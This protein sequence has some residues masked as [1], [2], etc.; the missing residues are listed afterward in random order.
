MKFLK[1]Y[2]VFIFAFLF[3]SQISFAYYLYG[4][5]P[6]CTWR[7]VSDSGS[8]F[9]KPPYSVG[10]GTLLN[11]TRDFTQ[12]TGVPPQL[13]N[14]DIIRDYPFPDEYVTVRLAALT[15]GAAN[16]YLES[17]PQKL[18][19]GEI[20]Y[21]LDS[22]NTWN[23]NFTYIKGYSSYPGI[24]MDYFTSERLKVKNSGSIINRIYE[25]TLRPWGVSHLS[26]AWIS[27]EPAPERAWSA[28]VPAW[29][30][31]FPSPY[32]GYVSGTCPGGIIYNGNCCPWGLGCPVYDTYPENNGPG[33]WAGP[34]CSKGGT[35]C[36]VP[37]YPE[38][39]GDIL[40]N[41]PAI[42]PIPGTDYP[43]VP[44][45]P[46]VRVNGVPGISCDIYNGANVNA[47]GAPA[48]P[49]C[50]TTTDPEDAIYESYGI[51]GYQ[52]N[53]AQ[54]SAK[55]KKAL[56]N[57]DVVDAIYYHG[58]RE[59][60]TTKLDLTTAP[61]TAVNSVG[62]NFIL[63]PRVYDTC[64][65][66]AS[67]AQVTNTIQPVWPPNAGNEQLTYLMGGNDSDWDMV[68][69]DLDPTISM[70]DDYL[71]TQCSATD[72][73]CPFP[74]PEGWIPV[75]CPGDPGCE[76]CYNECAPTVCNYNAGYNSC[77]C[78]GDCGNPPGCGAGDENAATS[79]DNGLAEIQEFK[80]SHSVSNLYLKVQTQ[81]DITFG[82]YGS[83]YPIVGCDEWNFG[84]NE[85]HKFNGYTFS[86]V[87]NRTIAAY[88]LIIVP[89]I[90][91]YG[92]FMI[93]LDIELLKSGGLSGDVAIEDL[94]CNSCQLYPDSA[95]AMG[96]ELYVELGREGTVG[97]PGSDPFTSY[98]LTLGL[99][100]LDFDDLLDKIQM[101]NFSLGALA[102]DISPAINYYIG[103]PISRSTVEVRNDTT[104][105]KVPT[106][107]ACLGSCD[108]YD[109][110]ARK[111]EVR[112]DEVLFNNDAINSDLTDLGGY[113]LYMSRGPQT[114][115]SHYYTFCGQVGE[116]S[117]SPA[118]TANCNAQTPYSLDRN[119]PASDEP[120]LP[121]GT[122][123]PLPFDAEASE[124]GFGFPG[125]PVSCFIDT[126]CD[127]VGDNRD[128]DT[129]GDV[130]EGCFSGA[131]TTLP[132][133]LHNC[134]DD[135][136]SDGEMLKEDG[137]EYWFKAVAY[138]RPNGNSS[139]WSNIAKVKILRNTTP[140]SVT[141]LQ[142]IYAMRQ[143]RSIKVVWETNKESDM[144][145]YAVYRCPASPIAAVRLTEQGGLAL[146]NYCAND[147]N[148]RRVNQT[149]LSSPSNYFIDYGT[150]YYEGSCPGC[151][152][153]EDGDA[154][155]YEWFDCT[156]T[157]PSNEDLM[158]C[159]NIAT[160][161]WT[162]GNPLTLYPASDTFRPVQ[163]YNGLVDGYVYYYKMRAVDRP[164]AG[165]GTN[166]PG[167][168]DAG[169][170]PYDPITKQGCVNPISDRTC[171]DDTV[172]NDWS[173]GGNCSDMS[174]AVNDNPRTTPDPETPS[175]TQP[176]NKPTGISSSLNTDGTSVT[177][178]W[179]SYTDLSSS[180]YDITFDHSNVYRSAVENG[181]FA[182]VRGTC[183]NTPMADGC[184]CAADGDCDTGRVCDFGVKICTDP[185][186]YTITPQTSGCTS[187]P[188]NDGCMCS[189]DSD[190]NTGRYCT[191]PT[192]VCKDPL[193]TIN[194]P[195][196]NDYTDNDGDGTIDEEVSDSVDNDNDG[197][198]DEDAASSITTAG[199]CPPP[200]L[201][202][203]GWQY[204]ESK[205]ERITSNSYTDRYLI[206]D[207][208][209]FYRISSVDNSVYD[210]TDDD[211][212]SPNEGKRSDII[213][214]TP[215][216]TEPPAKV[217]GTCQDPDTSAFE[218]C[219]EVRDDISP[220]DLTGNQL[221]ISWLTNT[222]EDLLGYYV[223]R[224]EDT[225]KTGNDPSTSK[226]LKLTE[227]PIS[228]P[229]ATTTVYF[230]DD[231]VQNDVD[232]YYAVT[233]LDTHYNEST[234]SEIAGPAEPGDSTPLSEP[235]EW[236]ANYTDNTNCTRARPTNCTTTVISTCDEG[237]V[238]Q[239][240][241]GGALKITWA[242]YDQTVC[243]P[244]SIE[245]GDF[246]Y[247]NLY[248]SDDAICNIT[249]NTNCTPGT[250]CL[251]ATDLAD[252]EYIDDDVTNGTTY[253][254]CISAVDTSGN[255]STVS[256]VKYGIPKDAVPP[257]VPS[258]LAATPLAGGDVGLGW[259]KNDDTDTA[260]YVIYRSTSS[261]EGTFTR[262]TLSPTATGYTII[263][264]D[265]VPDSDDE[266]PAINITNYTDEYNLIVGVTYY[267]KIT[268]IDDAGNE[269]AKTEAVSVV[270]ADID[271]AAPTQVTEMWAR[272]GF[273]VGETNTANSLDDDADGFIDDTSLL[274]KNVE[275]H[276]TV[277][278]VPDL[279]SYNVYR[280][281]PAKK[282]NCTCDKDG[283]PS[284][285][286][287]QT[288]ATCDE[289]DS[290]G[291]CDTDGYI[292][293]TDPCLCTPHSPNTQPFGTY[294]AIKTLDKGTACPA[295]HARPSGTIS[296]NTCIYRDTNQGQG[297]CNGSRYW[298][299]VTGV[300]TTGNEGTLDPNI[301][302][303]ATP[304]ERKCTAP[305]DKPAQPLIY[306]PTGG[307]KLSIRFKENDYTL[308]Q[309]ESVTG[310][311][312]YR[313]T[314]LQG[315]YMT[316]FTLNG[317]ENQLTHCDTADASP[318]Y[319]NVADSTYA[320]Y[321][322]ISVE[323]NKN[324]F[325]K[326]AA[327][328]ECGNISELSVVNRGTPLDSEAPQNATNLL[329]Q[330]TT[331][332]A[333]SLVITWSSYTLQ[334]DPSFA[335]FRLYRASAA[336]GTFVIID[337]VPTTS[338]VELIK[339]SSYIDT[340]LIAGETYC[341]ELKT[342]DINNQTSSGTI[343]CG[344]PGSDINAPPA[345][346][347]LIAIPGDKKVTLEW[348][349]VSSPDLAGYNVYRSTE[350]NGTY[351]KITAVTYPKHNDTGLTNGAIYW[352]YVTAF[353]NAS[354]PNESLPSRKISATPGSG[355]FQKSTS[356]GWNLI[357]LPIGA[358]KT[359]GKI[360]T[361]N[362]AG[363]S[364]KVFYQDPET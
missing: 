102:T 72:T 26:S 284:C 44:G 162:V 9:N 198:I 66:T 188:Y 302:Q 295:S 276:W 333:N 113:K 343:A 215:R 364:E 168:C 94:M 12:G 183:E 217:T 315:K 263:D 325:Y 74:R 117:F 191:Y 214:I 158:Y 56:G 169:Q 282:T 240:G 103:G 335:G 201:T 152:A 346:T 287:S 149:M 308:S 205:A 63:H 221:T 246:A 342:V 233:A 121:N 289:D 232:Y 280:L 91:I 64:G 17:T 242:P 62:S 176:P 235:P 278:P 181:I 318:C 32:D 30:V 61:L 319:C 361:T 259:F 344:I 219:A 15:D 187:T 11:Y 345:P 111:V 337:P 22:G 256:E 207:K 154:A 297:L 107:E 57:L 90:P 70:V 331:T 165:D 131:T 303:E 47:P 310:Y 171:T 190:C 304:E 118:E 226:Y 311:I 200:T 76:C 283:D 100:S 347:S 277:I 58:K 108:D 182:C 206:T 135:T 143:G 4:S 153:D 71:K 189:A 106:V 213:V 116:S 258:G 334:Q 332:S 99:H 146:S 13:S 195:A 193:T 363:S 267:Y 300:D 65:N 104:P 88:Y 351:T 159:G 27:G 150:G 36:N 313:D 38:G 340:N 204:D 362:G 80:I 288:G 141:N 239:Y 262:L 320:C 294:N 184:E 270:P 95:D 293:A 338:A 281:D 73:L 1:L 305:P 35:D 245:N 5:F 156:N 24:P 236:R 128:N 185:P 69:T 172:R 292:N 33:A 115:F 42:D 105:P 10:I 114:I 145:G 238:A 243:N 68:P 109:P 268:A 324:Y 237:S 354:T 54:G 327:F 40:D 352:Y 45:E 87:N 136:V 251:I 31:A 179:N 142:S 34:S 301:A 180:A 224:A 122:R 77:A 140:P 101:K 14:L 59:M 18:L 119:D 307:G 157:D 166:D 291:D 328:D 357:A 75:A 186:N 137:Q 216:D 120:Y 314:N 223:Y 211:L 125:E 192:R 285:D 123:F 316:Q 49:L 124:T 257:E 312:I 203:T 290:T 175:D 97:D 155:T 229:S 244:T 7:S 222:E 298:Y 265:G 250:D 78:T 356:R 112:W 139:T 160:D 253:Y 349:A 53:P 21:S 60:W 130:D 296:E 23:S 358:N 127:I 247:F 52:I 20:A 196:D 138:D 212:T 37:G 84:T 273:N 43:N 230:K 264:P 67:G 132:V 306:A 51:K 341:Y 161:T 110:M 248:R 19:F 199:L 269:S 286:T 6:H 252:A 360:A 322:D 225:N 93:F 272:P 249:T 164:Y 271:T 317:R 208:T 170:T 148:Y 266:I 323:N 234:F 218:P 41:F 339:G 8:Q 144:G 355:G 50:N 3:S 309:N 147:S 231:A 163:F 96:R 167:T 227:T 55:F 86:I 134:T 16:D 92:P 321:L 254:Y 194:N 2:I 129:D 274:S 174:P 133:T 330:P 79:P 228:Q 25:S 28:A 353:D 261:S 29:Y 48:H 350:M 275:L 348:D 202:A 126:D 241:G 177:L 178:N 46:I 89:P 279:T 98:V 299:L 151:A 85:A 255:E 173:K 329:V 326:V 81:A 210:R 220:S 83:W 359:A 260:G 39:G 336:S 197:L 82:C 209:Y